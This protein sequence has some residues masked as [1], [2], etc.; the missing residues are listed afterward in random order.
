[1]K[2]DIEP[3][4]AEY[5]NGLEIYWSYKKSLFKPLTIQH[6]VDDYIKMMEFFTLDPGKR[7]DDFK[8]KWK[9]RSFKRNF[10]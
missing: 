8:R 2:F 9:K 4:A 1:M 7:C 3:Y 10:N 6:L 5:K